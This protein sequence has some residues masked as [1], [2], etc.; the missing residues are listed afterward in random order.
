MVWEATMNKSFDDGNIDLAAYIDA[1]SADM[2][3]AMKQKIRMGK[4]WQ[5]L[6][7]EDIIVTGAMPSHEM[8]HTWSKLQQAKSPI[9]CTD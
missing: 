6:S 8:N 1:D 2:A 4:V 5:L 7:E 3:P 9:V